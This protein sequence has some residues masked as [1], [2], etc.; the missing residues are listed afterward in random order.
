MNSSK[1]YSD[2]FYSSRNASTKESAH[3]ILTTIFE[4]IRPNSIVDF[5][6]GVGTWLK[7][8]EELGIEEV[9]GLEGKWLNIKHLVIAKEKFFARDLSSK[10]LLEKRYD[11]AISLEVA[12]HVEEKFSQTFVE[13]LTN[14]SDIILFSA[15]I[16]GQRGS[17]HVNEQWPEYWIAIFKSHNYVPIDVIRPKVWNNNKV[18]SWYKQN[19]IL[20]VNSGILDNYPLLMQQFDEKKT[21][22]SVVHPA[23]FARQIEISNPKFSTLSQVLMSLPTVTKA[24]IKK[25]LKNITKL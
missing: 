15:A 17:G 14:A 5:G 3:E 22:W 4:F 12:E 20:F 10:L 25:F 18:K 7:I 6:C 19:T 21:M 9:T 8:A 1:L 24:S 23:T 2:S 11:L 13:N 16:P